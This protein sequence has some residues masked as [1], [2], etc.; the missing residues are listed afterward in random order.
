MSPT[1]TQPPLI[2]SSLA[3]DPELGELIAQFVAEMPSR[4]AW[5]Q[6]H[7]DAADWESLR[8]AA[9]QMK[10]AAASYGFEQLAPYAQRLE[11]LLTAG[12]ARV[13]ITAALVELVVHCRAVTAE[14]KAPS[15]RR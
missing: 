8:R 4:V 6:R 7:F 2:H 5:L 14:S 11:K 12:A 15:S 13:D 3:S 10:G 9:H 1:R